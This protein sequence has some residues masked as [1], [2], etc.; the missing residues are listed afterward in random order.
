MKA[1]QLRSYRKAGTGNPVFVYGVTGNPTELEAY[2]EAQGSNF[3]ED[4]KT[5]Q[6]LWFT[7]RF[8]GKSAD[9]IITSKGSVV[10]DTSAFD[11]AASIAAQYGG[12]LGQELAKQAA[13]NLLGFAPPAPAPVEAPVAQ[14]EAEADASEVDIS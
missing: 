1:V 12:N 2:K 14:P 4:D 10:A 9:L 8:V 11:Q 3:R 6:A 5:G 13:L 7:T